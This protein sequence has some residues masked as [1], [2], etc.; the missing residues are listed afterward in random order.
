MVSSDSCSNPFRRLTCSFLDLIDVD[1][2]FLA[3]GGDSISGEL[4]GTSLPRDANLASLAMSVSRFLS[5]AGSPVKTQDVLKSNS[6][7]EL[8]LALESRETRGSSAEALPSNRSRGSRKTP[9]VD[10]VLSEYG[11]DLANR[12][13]IIS[14][15][16]STPFQ[17]RTTSSLFTLPW[18]PYLYNLFAEIGGYE[19]SDENLDPQ[20]LLSAW[21]ATITRHPILRTA[22]PLTK[23][24]AAAHQFIL[25]E[26]AVSSGMFEVGVEEEALKASIEKTEHVKSSLSST[27]LTPPLWLD[28]YVTSTKKVYMHLLMGHMLIDHVSLAHV[29]YDWDVF[30]RGASSLLKEAGCLPSFASYVDDVESRDP[31]VSTD[32]WAR[33]LRGAEPTILGPRP[34]TFDSGEK[35]AIGADAMS[36]VNFKIDIDAE[37]DKYCRSTRVTVS[38]LLQFAWGVLLSAYTGQASVCFG[39]LASDRDIDIS[40]ADEIVGPMLTVLITHVLLEGQVEEVIRKLQADNT[41]SMAHK[42]FNLS[43]I[44]QGLGLQLPRRPLFN[45]LVNYRKVKRSGPEPVMKLRSLLK[46]DPHEVSHE[47]LVGHNAGATCPEYIIAYI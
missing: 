35:L 30:Y 23:A 5:Q 4:H 32:F 26:S 13:R 46:Q 21:R 33:R 36:A 22:I 40:N 29:L 41:D 3:L 16:H 27:T 1:D 18:K 19:H 7:R 31:S 38:N 28:L 45:T 34:G 25:D 43:A 24:G 37:M 10:E 17:S 42:V 15:H 11:F 12:S 20:R 6:I 9:S 8:A 14:V 2:H 44:E 47:I 39:H